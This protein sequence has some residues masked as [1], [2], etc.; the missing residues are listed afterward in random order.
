MAV[1]PAVFSHLGMGSTLEADNGNSV[2]HSTVRI[3][4]FQS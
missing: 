4:L 3:S 1:A 2:Y